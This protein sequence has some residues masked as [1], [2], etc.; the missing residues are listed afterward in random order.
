M[1]T[2]GKLETREC[3]PDSQLFLL[4]T[5]FLPTITPQAATM[6]TANVIASFR[7]VAF[8]FSI[9]SIARATLALV[10][11]KGPMV[12][13]WVIPM[14]TLT[15]LIWIGLAFAL[16]GPKRVRRLPLLAFLAGCYLTFTGPALGQAAIP[17]Q[18]RPLY[19]ELDETLRQ[20]RQ[21]YPFQKGK[22]RPLVAPS[23][24]L[25]GSGYGPAASDSQRWKDL[26]ATLDAFKGMRMNAVSVMI[27]APDLTAGDPAPLIG[28]YQRLT[29]EI[30]K[31][32]MKFYVEHFV[33]PPF[34]PRAFKGLR[35]DPEG[36]RRTSAGVRARALAGGALRVRR[37][38][39]PRRR[40][41][42][43][44]GP[45]PAAAAAGRHEE[46][47]RARRGPGRARRED[48]ARNPRRGRRESGGRR[49]V[50]DA[51]SGEDE[52]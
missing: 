17:D 22:P 28:F 1:L 40:D 9:T 30:H 5:A 3:E 35:D 45:A 11:W 27:A 49:R 42:R 15:L 24:F 47:G 25:A 4:K 41:V 21:I 26:L 31:R 52:R 13:R 46:A 38:P 2:Q 43:R 23:L 33:P 48:R 19:R 12:G 29:S 7:I 14:A 37:Q 34:S 16:M 32:G 44:S 20:A 51:V 50:A 39:A 10:F 36:R 6:H 8:S 18:F